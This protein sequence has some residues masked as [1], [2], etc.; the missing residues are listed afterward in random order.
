MEI[1]RVIVWEADEDEGNEYY[2]DT[3]SN[4]EKFAAKLVPAY[5]WDLHLQITR[6]T[7]LQSTGLFITSDS[8][9]RKTLKAKYHE[10][11]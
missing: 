2:F 8:P 11:L 10:N 5:Y 3:L 6:L 4:A 7:S 1:Y 9:A